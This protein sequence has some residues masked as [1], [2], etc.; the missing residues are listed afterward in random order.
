MPLRI[1]AALLLAVV[2]ISP[3]GAARTEVSVSRHGS[4]YLIE[5]SSEV[6]AERA[7]VWAVLTDYEGYTRFVPGLRRSWKAGADPLRIE[8]SGEFGIL[9]FRRT[10]SA[11]LEIEEHPM[12]HIV[13]RGVAGDLRKLETAVAVEGDGDAN[14]HL[15]RYRSAIE[16]SFWV[17]PVIGT[18][19]IR[20]AI[21][22][23]LQAV[24]E[25]IER[26]AGRQ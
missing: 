21:R 9:F 12:S 13:L 10:L 2:L 8:Q 3:A 14:R 26:R 11:T 22:G 16:P 6:Q 20:M 4:A 5:A 18:S 1:P 24:A 17:P 15:V 25:E 19:I 23:K 7:V